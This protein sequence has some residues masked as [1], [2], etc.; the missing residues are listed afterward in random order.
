MDL[1]LTFRITG[2]N[3]LSE[4]RA[5]LIVASAH[6][7]VRAYIRSGLKNRILFQAHCAFSEN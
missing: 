4:E 7:I 1:V 6:A 5:A 2:G 3:M